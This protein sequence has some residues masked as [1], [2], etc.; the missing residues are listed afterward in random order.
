MLVDPATPDPELIDVR[1]GTDATG[2]L[3]VRQNGLRLTDT[4]AQPGGLANR[5]IVAQ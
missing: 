1:R 2:A 5:S 4:Q 3:T